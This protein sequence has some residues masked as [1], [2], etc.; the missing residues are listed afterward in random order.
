MANCIVCNQDV[1]KQTLSLHVKGKENPSN[2]IEILASVCP[3][4]GV[5]MLV[6]PDAS[7]TQLLTTSF[8]E[9]TQADLDSIDLDLIFDE[10]AVPG[11]DAD[12]SIKWVDPED[13]KDDPYEAYYQAMFEEG[14][15]K[16]FGKYKRLIHF[17]K[18]DQAERLEAYGPFRASAM[19]VLPDNNV[20]FRE[21]RTRFMLFRFM[22]AK[23]IPVA[24]SP[25]H[26]ANAEAAGITLYD[27]RE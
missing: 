8:P 23:R 2:R 26:A 15:P 10:M 22:G 27:T 7:F 17:L 19:R 3:N 25:E 16:S 21:G 13:L 11:K 5:L 24:V 1:E 4:C 18:M 12:E 14:I 20:S 6:R 9:P